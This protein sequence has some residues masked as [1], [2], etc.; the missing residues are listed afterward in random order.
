MIL[1]SQ[2]TARAAV[3][4]NAGVVFRQITS[5]VDE[6]GPKQALRAQGATAVAL[7]LAHAKAASVDPGDGSLV[8]GADQI[9]VCEGVWFD[10]PDGL[11]GARSHLRALRGRTHELVTAVVLRRGGQ[12]LWEHVAV[13]RL[14]MRDVSDAG[15]DAMLALDGAECVH[16][17][18][19]YRVEGPGV[20]LFSAIEGEWAAIL[21][22]PLLQLLGAIRH[23][24][25]RAVM[26]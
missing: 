14:T 24:E 11:A 8:I 25:P 9:L 21:G 5:A 26:L 16:C 7:H 20:Q 3:L 23:F 10:K 15:I 22:L 6:D 12:A 1:A 19:G 4:R 2:S 18:G 13:P 17:V